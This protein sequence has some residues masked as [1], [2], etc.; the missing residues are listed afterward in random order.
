M[1]TAIRMRDISVIHIT[2]L[3]DKAQGLQNA[4]KDIK[5]F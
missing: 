2:V 4:I 3:I 5:M 1:S